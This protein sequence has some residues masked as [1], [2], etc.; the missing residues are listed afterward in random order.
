MEGRKEYRKEIKE[1]RGTI[2]EDAQTPLS[3]SVRCIICS[4]NF[5]LM[6]WIMYSAVFYLT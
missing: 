1:G 3:S 6:I 4:K 5:W 2:I